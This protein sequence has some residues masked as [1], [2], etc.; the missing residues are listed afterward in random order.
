VRGL[1]ARLARHRVVPVLTVNDERAVEP[2][3]RALLAG[4]VDVVEITYRTA[5]ATAAIARLRRELPELLILAG[6]VL[7]PAQVAEASAAGAQAIVA[8]A[9]SLAV[10]EAARC[11]GLA[12]IP[13]VGT[14]SEVD[15]ARRLGLSLV[16]IFP[17]AQLG[18]AAYLRAL[19]S[20]FPDMAFLPTGGLTASDLGDYASLHFVAACGLG[21]IATPEL[22]LSGR[23]DVITARAAHAREMMQSPAAPQ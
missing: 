15:Q 4:G 6:T 5:V 9:L 3:A 23:Y 10:V 13:G 17:A 14:A 22:I 11:A 20:V 2:L 1:L 16:K 8:P 19:H 21:S 18:G 7:E 12:M